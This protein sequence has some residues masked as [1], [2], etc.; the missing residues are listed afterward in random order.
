VANEKSGQ[1]EHWKRARKV[2]KGRRSRLGKA[3][4]DHQMV[5]HAVGSRGK[6]KSG[7]KQNPIR[8]QCIRK[9]DVK[10]RGEGGGGG[11]GGKVHGASSTGHHGEGGMRHVVK[12]SGTRRRRSKGGGRRGGGCK[13]RRS[14]GALERTICKLTINRESGK[15]HK[16]E[17]SYAQ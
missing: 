9:E 3:L 1:R 12:L 2:E 15:T 4:S 10:G 11:K 13:K 14:Q 5:K 6:Q 8:R 16:D 17:R 7:R